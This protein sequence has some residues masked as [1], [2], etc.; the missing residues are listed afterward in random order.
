MCLRRTGRTPSVRMEYDDDDDEQ[1]RTETQK[2]VFREEI[3]NRFW[4]TGFLHFF[5]IIIIIAAAVLFIF[6]F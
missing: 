1:K 5:I 3:A 6:F 2:R 4:M